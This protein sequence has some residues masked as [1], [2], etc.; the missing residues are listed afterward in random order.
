MWQSSIQLL[1][2]K[3]YSGV[4][5][6]LHKLLMF[7]SIVFDESE[8]FCAGAILYEVLLTE[9]KMVGSFIERCN[10]ACI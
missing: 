4:H 5:N 8:I 1:C 10:V 2:I 3:L 9:H 6:M 7:E